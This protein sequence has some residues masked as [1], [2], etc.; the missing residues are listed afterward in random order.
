MTSEPWS[1]GHDWMR[2][3]PDLELH[4]DPD[5]HPDNIP[6]VIQLVARSGVGVGPEWHSDGL[7]GDRSLHYLLE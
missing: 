5:H 6:L 3:D 1:H 7:V 4:L 2:F